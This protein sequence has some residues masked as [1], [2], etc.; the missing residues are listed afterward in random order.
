M[1]GERERERKDDGDGMGAQRT[2]TGTVAPRQSSSVR[3]APLERLLRGRPALD[4][5]GDDIER[6]SKV[7]EE[8]VR[9]ALAHAVRREVVLPVRLLLHEEHVSVPRGGHVCVTAQRHIS[10]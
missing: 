1:E 8:D 9:D 5:G 4:D 6:A 2:A 10:R 3:A 7:R